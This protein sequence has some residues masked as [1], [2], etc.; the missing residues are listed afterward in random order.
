[1]WN[2]TEESALGRDLHGRRQRLPVA[3]Q[4]ARVGVLRQVI[5]A[6]NN[7]EVMQ[8][9]QDALDLMSSKGTACKSWSKAPTQGAYVSRVFWAW[10]FGFS[11]GLGLGFAFYG[12]QLIQ[13]ASHLVL[14]RLGLLVVLSTA[15][16]CRE[17]HRHVSRT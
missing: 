1:M 4:G 9:F 2:F 10:P 11:V 6:D 8:L 5:S 7:S 3:G 15:R 17:G 12:C 13:E 14:L 16:S